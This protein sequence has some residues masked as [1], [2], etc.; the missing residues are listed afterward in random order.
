MSAQTA[1][2]RPLGRPA[3]KSLE[4]WVLWLLLGAGAIVMIAPFYWMIVTAFKSRSEVMV[5]PP[6]WW[7]QQPTLES[8]VALTRLRGGFH[9]FF[10]NSLFVSICITL[11]VL[12][13]SAMAGYVFAK[14]EFRGRD[15]LFIMI[16]SLLM[17]PF[18]VYIIPLYKLMVDLGWTN[19]YWALIIPGIYSPLGIFLMRQFLHSIPNDLI[20]AARVDGASEWG[21]FF[22][23]IL[24]LSTAALAALGIFTFTWSW[25]DFL[26][27]LVIID[28]PQ[29]YTLPLGLSQLRG[30]FG[31]DVG[32]SMAGAMVAVLPV[33]IVY[34]FAQRRFIEGITLSGLKG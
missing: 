16:L 20:D 18:N 21:I 5:F 10:A 33:L 13:T 23:I 31:T 32:T 19:S 27:P 11:L 14:F 8:W 28:E 24:P 2:I 29:R 4:K 30:R 22:R 6:T 34:L 3:G 17:I 1:H 9:L 7:P 26:W 12:L 15:L 25:D